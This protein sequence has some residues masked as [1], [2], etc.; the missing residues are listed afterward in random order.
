MLSPGEAGREQ[1][2]TPVQAAANF[3]PQTF[4]ALT[5]TLLVGSMVDRSRRAGCC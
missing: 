3:L 1:G 4:A 2:L 5:A